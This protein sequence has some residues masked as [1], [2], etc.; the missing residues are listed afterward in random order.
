MGDRF[1]ARSR[2]ATL[3]VALGAVGGFVTVLL[4]G[5]VLFAMEALSPV[6]ALLGV[7]LLA[8][9]G[10]ALWLVVRNSD[11]R[12]ASDEL[13]AIPLLQLVSLAER[14]DRRIAGLAF[15]L[16]ALGQ[17]VLVSV[18]PPV[19]LLALLAGL[20]AM[21]TLDPAPARGRRES[22][23]RSAPETTLPAG[24]SGPFARALAVVVGS[25][26]AVVGLALG[27]SFLAR[28]LSAPTMEARFLTG[29][30]IGSVTMLL[31]GGLFMALGLGID[32]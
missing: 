16:G 18:S 27:W 31:F 30:G 24:P 14:L 9:P 5:F 7:A 17:F 3:Y 25:I 13:H 2:Q 22:G 15:V 8:G 29:L 12:P 6:S 28:G 32:R 21:W 20:V 19:S 4:V 1:D 10:L 23:G 11:Q 26:F